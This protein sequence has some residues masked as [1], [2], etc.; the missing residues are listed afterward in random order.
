M[1]VRTFILEEDV[2]KF[3]FL[4]KEFPPNVGEKCVQEP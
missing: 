4:L 3:T 1:S 2:E